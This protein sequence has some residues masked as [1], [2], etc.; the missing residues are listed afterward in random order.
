M[1]EKVLK[2]LESIG[3][4]KN[5]ISVYIDLIKTGSSTAHDI[6]HRTKIHRSNVYDIIDKLIEK[7]IVMES[8]ENNVKTFYPIKPKNLMNYLKQKEYA[9]KKIIPQIEKMHSMPKSKKRKVIM[10]EG[11]KAVR[12]ILDGFLEQ[13]K[14][15]YVYGI[16]KCALEELG[17]FIMDYHKRRIKKKIPMKHIYNKNAQKRIKQL[18]KMKY[19]E[20]GYLPELYNTNITTNICGNKVVLIFWETPISVMVIENQSIADAYQ[21][22]FD[23]LWEKAKPTEQN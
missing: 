4:H 6:S 2:T 20:A 22:Y 16:P 19:T 13:E 11:I 17:G 23:I 18:N 3:L 10:I 7:G 9:L 1:E 14:P 8:I 5:E 21:K 12:S 15:I